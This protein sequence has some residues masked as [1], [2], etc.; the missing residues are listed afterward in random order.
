MSTD[1][2]V[3]FRYTFKS[4]KIKKTAD[5]SEA[6]FYPMKKYKFVFK[7]CSFDCLRS[8]KMFDYD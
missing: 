1:Y 3:V 2:A 5:F 7:L 4:G 8:L 6:F